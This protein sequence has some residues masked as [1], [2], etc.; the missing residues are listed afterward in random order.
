MVLQVDRP[1]QREG[2]KLFAILDSK[3]IV[4]QAD[5]SP[6]GPKSYAEIGAVKE[7]NHASPVRISELPLGKQA[8]IE[9]HILI[10]ECSQSRNSCRQND[11]FLESDALVMADSNRSDGISDAKA[12]F[13]KENL[14][15]E[16]TGHLSSPHL[17]CNGK[18]SHHDQK[19]VVSIEYTCSTS[20]CDL[21]GIDSC[22]SED[23]KEEASTGGKS[24]LLKMQGSCEED[25][26]QLG[27]FHEPMDTTHTTHQMQLQGQN[28]ERLS[29]SVN[30]GQTG[31]KVER[32]AQGRNQEG[33]SGLLQVD[34]TE[35]HTVALWVK[36]HIIRGL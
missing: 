16:E 36:V 34:Y 17:Q 5:Q 23:K 20:G 11:S 27:S 24:A 33:E 13:P 15:K 29:A 9:T 12:L 3:S 14:C 25:K 18:G 32:Q 31:G 35:D 7:C 6:H 4:F 10:G 30:S 8:I 26:D 19:G 1:Q 2:D 22:I 28:C 21:P